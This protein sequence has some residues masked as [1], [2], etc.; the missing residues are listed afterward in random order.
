M[1]KTKKSIDKW[2][3]SK[4][5][6]Y[7]LQ[8]VRLAFTHNT[9]LKTDLLL[10][11]VHVQLLCWLMTWTHGGRLS[12]RRGHQYISCCAGSRGTQLALHIMEITNL[13]YICL[14]M[15]WTPP[16]LLVAVISPMFLALARMHLLCWIFC[17]RSK[18]VLKVVLLLKSSKYHVPFI[19]F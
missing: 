16:W 6:N 7:Y 18:D 13:N 12:N 5:L 15:F 10:L 8:S 19:V 4:I 17:A 2:Q 9:I 1:L 14:L 3:V 11:F